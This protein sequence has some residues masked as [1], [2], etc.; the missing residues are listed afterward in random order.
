MYEGVTFV[1]RENE[2]GQTELFVVH[3][4][5]SETLFAVDG[6]LVRVDGSA[7]ADWSIIV[8]NELADPRLKQPGGG[9]QNRP[10]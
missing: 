3:E 7:G 9:R 4:D 8:R 10:L 1:E 5:G 2:R 6:K